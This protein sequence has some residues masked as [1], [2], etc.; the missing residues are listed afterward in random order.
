MNL[1]LKKATFYP[2]IFLFSHQTRKQKI[3]KHHEKE[4]EQPKVY[5]LQYPNLQ[6]KDLAPIISRERPVKYLTPKYDIPLEQFMPNSDAILD[7]KYG[8][9]WKSPE[10]AYSLNIGLIGPANAGKS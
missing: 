5:P 9:K 1:V 4:P 8:G 6:P 2:Q 10:N 7:K 3:F